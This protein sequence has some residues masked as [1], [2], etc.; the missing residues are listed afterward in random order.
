MRRRR[1]RARSRSTT[2]AVLEA[3][4]ARWRPRASRSL[5]IVFLHAYANPRHERAGGSSSSPR[6]HPDARAVRLASTWRRR[7]ASTS[8][9]PPRSSTPTS[10]RWPSAIS[11]RWP[12]SVAG[13][14]HRGAAAAD[15]VERRPH[16]RRARPSAR[17]CSCWN[18]AR[19]RAR[20]PPPS[21]ARPTAAATCS[22][23]TWAAPPP[24]S[25]SST[26][27]SRSIAYSFEAARAAALH[28]GQRPAHPH[29]DH[30]ADRD[31]RRRRLASPT[32]TRSA[33]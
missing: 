19:R 28:R 8:A 3:G 22:P 11:P 16:P 6:R 7:S 27:A 12:R 29:L 2:R 21:S 10:S 24:S 20:W 32:S 26:A 17:R 5:A 30:R 25:A 23:S 15:A 31:R 4:G 18:R 1:Q 9:P 14:R 33:C 13:L